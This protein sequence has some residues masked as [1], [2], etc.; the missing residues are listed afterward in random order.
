[1]ASSEIVGDDTWAVF[2]ARK[3]LKVKWDESEA[4]S[5]SW[6]QMVSDAKD[7]AK[8]SGSDIKLDNPAVANAL[9]DKN[10]R[11]LESFYEF[12]QHGVFHGNQNIRAPSYAYRHDS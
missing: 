6:E 12:P 10:N 8:G 3:S 5:D 2:N 1:M 9:T 7:A 11:V 4:S